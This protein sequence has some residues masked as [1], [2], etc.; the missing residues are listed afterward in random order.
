MTNKKEEYIAIVDD[1]DNLIGVEER[2][3]VHQQGLLHRESYAFLFNKEKELLLTKTGDKKLLDCSS[4]GHFS[5]NEDYETGILRE[6]K[7]E[8]GYKI[9]KSDLKEIFKLKF[10]TKTKQKI[11]KRFVKL[12]EINKDVAINDFKIDNKEIIEIQFMSLEKLKSKTKNNPELFENRFIE[13]F[14]E[15]IKTI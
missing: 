7:E 15:Y 10:N 6:I 2:R 8:V 13:A 14:S 4:A 1:N 5:S 9:N 11:N 12:F 3:K